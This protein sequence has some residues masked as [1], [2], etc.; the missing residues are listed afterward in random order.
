MSEKLIATTNYSYTVIPDGGIWVPS[1]PT[2]TKI[3]SSKIKCEDN[4]ILLTSLVF[5]FVGC[6]DG[7]FVGRGGGSISATCTKCTNSGL[8][9]LREDDD[10]VCTGVLTNPSSG[11]TKSCKCNLKISS[12][13]Q[14]KVKAI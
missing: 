11:A 1:T 12:A 4:F 13:G 6:V 8:I 2:I 7:D 14:T 10:G 3:E 9:P 5:V